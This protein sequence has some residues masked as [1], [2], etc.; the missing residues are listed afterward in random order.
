MERRLKHGNNA[1]ISLF[2]LLTPDLSNRFFYIRVTHARTP[3]PDN[4]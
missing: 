3:E 2:F 1:N 4:M